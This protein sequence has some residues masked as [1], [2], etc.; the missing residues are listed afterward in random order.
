MIVVFF[1]ITIVILVLV[2][3]VTALVTRS[4]RRRPFFVFDTAVRASYNS[5]DSATVIFFFFSSSSEV[6]HASSRRYCVGGLFTS[7]PSDTRTQQPTLRYRPRSMSFAP[8]ASQQLSA[9]RR[10]HARDRE[11]TAP[12]FLFSFVCAHSINGKKKGYPPYHFS[13]PPRPQLAS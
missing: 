4:S 2:V 6:V 1:H 3:L 11:S 9:T 8:I 12:F 5:Y 7:R 10:Q 13:L